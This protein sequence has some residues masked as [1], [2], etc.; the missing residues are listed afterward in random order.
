MKKGGRIQRYK[1]DQR[2]REEEKNPGGT[3]DVCLL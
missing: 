3:M 1:L 2:N